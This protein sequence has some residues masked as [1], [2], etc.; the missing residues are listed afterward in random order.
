MKVYLIFIN[1]RKNIMKKKILSCLIFV[2]AIFCCFGFTACGGNKNEDNGENQ[3]QE[4]EI[5]LF[6]LNDESNGYI[7]DRYYGSDSVVVVSESY[8]GLPITEIGRAFEDN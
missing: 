5:F 4:D 8:K 1:E 6:I 7:L 2:F 3:N